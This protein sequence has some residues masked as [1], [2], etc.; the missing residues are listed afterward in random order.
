MTPAEMENT[1]LLAADVSQPR[2]Q[3]EATKQLSKWMEEAAQ[4]VVNCILRLLQTTN[5][6]A[7][8]FFSLTTLQR[9]ELHPNEQRELQGILLS[10]QRFDCMPSYM[11]VKIGIVLAKVLQ[12]DLISFGDI[13]L[14]KLEASNP[15][16]YLRTLDALFE[17]TYSE[18][19]PTIR[20]LKDVLRGISTS[21][22]SCTSVD[23][24]MAARIF[25]RLFN[26]L[27]Q[28]HYVTLNLTVIKKMV[29]WIDLSLLLQDEKLD[30]LYKYLRDG[31]QE[32]ALIVME[33]FSELFSRGMDAPKKVALVQEVKILE[34]IDANINLETIDQSPIEIVIEAA[35]FINLLGLELITSWENRIVPDFL[36][37]KIIN[38]FFRCF[39]YDD[40]DVSGAVIPLACR[41]GIGMEPV[42]SPSR[43][44]LP[45]LLSIMFNQM[46]YPENFQFDYNDEDE[47]EEEVYRT[48]LRKFNQRLVRSLP[49]ACLQFTC[50][51][52]SNLPNPISSSPT[53]DIEAALRLIFHYGEGI[54]PSP[55]LKTVMKNKAFVSILQALHQSDVAHHPHRE[56][57]LLYYDIAVRY[58][59]VYETH[60]IL[61]PK[62]LDALS[63]NR[64]IQH[65][66]VRVRS[67][68]CYLLL[69]LIKRLIKLMKAYV[70]NAVTG[71]C[72]LLSNPTKYP[73]CAE[74]SLYLF[75]T[76]GILLGETGLNE[77][78]QRDTLTRVIRP[79][80]HNIE[81]LL[82][83]SNLI[84]DSENCGIMLSDSVASIAWL[85]K[86]FHTPPESVKVILAETLTITLSVFQA[87][88]THQGV[89]KSCTGLWQRMVQCIGRK[90]LACT[91]NY[92][93]LQIT[94]C[95]SEDFQIAAQIMMQCCIKFKEEAAPILDVALLPFL[96]KC[97]SLLSEN[98][99]GEVPP[100]RR[101]EQ[102][103]I[104]KSS[105]VVIQHIVTNKAAA[106]LY[107]SRN[108]GNFQNILHTM[109]DGAL[110]SDN[111]LIQK[112]CLQFFR[113]FLLHLMPEMYTTTNEANVQFANFLYEQLCPA[114]LQFIQS[115][116]FDEMDAMQLRNLSE[117][118][119]ILWD[120][121]SIRG[122]DEFHRFLAS[123]ENCI[124][125]GS[126]LNSLK[127]V[128]SGKEIE[129][130]LLEILKATNSNPNG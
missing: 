61:L 85:S 48:E 31:S 72:T 39:A 18:I 52:L 37:S 124:M 111:P 97:H 22:P 17:S 105:F 78:I 130:C 119:Q 43:S 88:P 67:R 41:I 106:V 6:E 15:I 114:W 53:R 62:I 83:N 19:D 11:Q 33:L 100:H 91:Q 129:L 65:E 95:C 66:H 84:Q 63:S 101:I 58:A 60:P 122:D 1:V 54:R 29:S 46:K 55:G 38:L 32:M 36:W 7:V 110:K 86:G 21:S 23:Q 40:I 28:N 56:V 26:M 25:I 103:L 70:E 125:S 69:K 3:W 5:H 71:I 14:G 128:T 4:D 118:S 90:V 13:V 59:A 93:D 9:L 126:I 8:I 81:L 24:T 82:N 89:R 113:E 96:R 35:K 112:T 2:L 51:E 80:V 12:A 127:A 68:S 47:T 94:H 104:Q 16:L 123:L 92:L 121:K 117:F 34:C 50:T 64:G 57:L 27:D 76:V 77:E 120:L 44:L 109:K 107:S 116:F 73:I 20:E 45:Q 74:D 102:D 87:L 98:E 75:E 49:D 10:S 42:D 99:I 79:H 108:R 115:P 30:M